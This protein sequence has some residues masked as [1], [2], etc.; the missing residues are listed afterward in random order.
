MKNY[1]KPT[2]E[3]LLEAAKPLIKYLSENYHPHNICIVD[4]IGAEVLEGQAVVKT[5]EFLRD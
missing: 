2:N 5:E 4:S 3:K 1:D